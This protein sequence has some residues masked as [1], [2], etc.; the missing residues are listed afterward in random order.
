LLVDL[1]FIKQERR[2]AGL[3]L[4]AS[5]ARVNLGFLAHGPREGRIT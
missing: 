2:S 3:D 1:E 5:L 4:K